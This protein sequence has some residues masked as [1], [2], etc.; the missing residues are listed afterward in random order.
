MELVLHLLQQL[1]NLEV[2]QIQAFEV[3]EGL[4]VLHDTNLAASGKEHPLYLYIRLLAERL[5]Q[6]LDQFLVLLMYGHFLVFRRYYLVSDLPEE[7]V[8]IV[9]DE[10]IG[11]S[12]SILL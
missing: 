8:C 5:L 1:L 7:L 4:V 9:F 6:E 3:V 10:F 2:A 12:S 11:G